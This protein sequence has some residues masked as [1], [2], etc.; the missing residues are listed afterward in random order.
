[1]QMATAWLCA[2]FM[3]DSFA[4]D[5]SAGP[6][7]WLAIAGFGI[8]FLPETWDIRFGTSRKWA[9]VYAAGML[10]AYFFINGSDTVFLYYQF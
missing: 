2:M 8:C 1:M 6:L 3:P 10:M 5:V 4:S 7:A 9:P